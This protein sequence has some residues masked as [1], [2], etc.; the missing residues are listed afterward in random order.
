[1]SKYKG[2]AAPGWTLVII[3]GAIHCRNAKKVLDLV[4]EDLLNE[5]YGL[6]SEAFELLLQLGLPSL[7]DG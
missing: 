2:N 4:L 5:Y 3:P 1:M 6:A 7:V